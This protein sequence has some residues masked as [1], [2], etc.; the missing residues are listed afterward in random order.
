MLTKKELYKLSIKISSK[1]LA[2]FFGAPANSFSNMEA[3]VQRK[4]ARKSVY[5]TLAPLLIAEE[6][7][8]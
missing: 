4:A 1:V 2:E 6:E 5:E 7:K 3:D 8:K